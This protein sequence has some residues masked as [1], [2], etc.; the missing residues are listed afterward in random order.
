MILWFSMSLF[1]WSKLIIFNKFN[2]WAHIIIIRISTSE[3]GFSNSSGWFGV[4]N[5][6]CLTRLSGGWL[7]LSPLTSPQLSKLVD[8]GKS[9]KIWTRLQ[10]Q[11][12][13]T[14]FH[15]DFCIFWVLSR[16]LNFVHS[17]NNS[18]CSSDRWQKLK[19][20]PN[21]NIFT[22]SPEIETNK[23]RIYVFVE[24]IFH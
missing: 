18:W 17:S 10:H 12:G 14:A 7:A 11:S 8:S 3:P 16:K 6:D 13:D 5:K 9:L 23:K 15:E 20:S 1:L 21:T 4:F 22:F 19:I 2:F 24:N